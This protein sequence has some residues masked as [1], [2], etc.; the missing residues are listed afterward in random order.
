MELRNEIILIYFNT[1]GEDYFL[2]DIVR[3]LGLTYPQV[4]ER[5]NYLVNKELLAYNKLGILTISIRGIE[6][7]KKQGFNKLNIF[8]I[9]HQEKKGKIDDAPNQEV[10]IPLN[11][12]KKFN[13]YN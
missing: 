2:S 1:V 13:G 3:T 8:E 10:Y 4:Q 6:Y 7:L 12:N 5:I 11:F 9:Y